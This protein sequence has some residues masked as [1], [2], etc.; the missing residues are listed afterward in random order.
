MRT[1]LS[2]VLIICGTLLASNGYG[3]CDS[4]ASLCQ[5]HL[6]TKY[7]SDGQLY[8]ALLNGDEVAEFHATFY[9][10]S[11]YRICGC[12]GVSDGNLIFSLYDEL[13]NLLFT[14]NDYR[15]APYWD[16]EFKT[17]V[18]CR[19]EAKLETLE[20]SSGCAVLL[21]GFER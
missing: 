21:I 3:Q 10:S 6:S 19:I 12:S 9:G 13:D 15:N 18:Q 2:I 1:F 17:T 11:K 20:Q 14:N 8:R 5:G 7:I 4:T 16:F